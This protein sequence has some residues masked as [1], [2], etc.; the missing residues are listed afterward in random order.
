LTAAD[1]GGARRITEIIAPER[2]AFA[3]Y[4]SLLRRVG[5]PERCLICLGPTATVMAVD[6]CANGVHA[7]D[8]GHVGMFLRKHRTG[9]PMVLSKDDKSYDKVP[10]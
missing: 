3:D 5:T 10:A 8:L 6:L 9:V 2:D 4:D 7:I 1:L